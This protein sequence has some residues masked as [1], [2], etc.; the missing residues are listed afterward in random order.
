MVPE[1]QKEGG[2]TMKAE[3][4]SLG[5]SYIFRDIV[6][7]AY[8][9]VESL[10]T[11]IAVS[12]KNL[13]KSYIRLSRCFDKT[14]QRRCTRAIERSRHNQLHPKRFKHGRQERTR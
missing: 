6:Q 2:Y 14:Y 5:G 4:N 8:K 1:E 3:N 12:F 7:A 10:T 13:K 11:G 9:L